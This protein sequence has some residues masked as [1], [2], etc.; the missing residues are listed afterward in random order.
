MGCRWTTPISK[1]STLAV[2]DQSGASGF[3]ASRMSLR[4]GLSPRTNVQTQCVACNN[5]TCDATMQ[6]CNIQGNNRAYGAQRLT[7]QE[8]GMEC[9]STT[10][11]QCDSATVRQCDSAKSRIHCVAKTSWGSSPI[12]SIH[13][14][15]RASAF[16]AVS[17]HPDVLSNHVDLKG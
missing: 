5:A 7:A 10:V 12:L 1:C 9:N 2:K 3:T 14:C 15:Q 8:C 17:R 16:A 6:R 11:R 13:S 4:Y